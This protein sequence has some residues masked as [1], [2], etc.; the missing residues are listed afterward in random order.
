MLD[1]VSGEKMALRPTTDTRSYPVDRHWI[2]ELLIIGIEEHVVFNKSFERYELGDGGVNVH[3]TDGSTVTGR[4]VIG[5]DGAHSRVRRQFLPESRLLDLERTIIWGRTPL[6]PEF[7]KRFNRPDVLAEHFACMVDPNDNRH[8][9]FFAPLRWSGNGKLSRVSEKLK[10]QEDYM[11]LALNFE[12]PVGKLDTK[13]AREEHAR[14]IS[15]G[16]DADLCNLLTMM[17]ESSA[18]RVHSSRP[19]VEVW[20]TDDR[21]TLLGDAIHLMSPSGGSGGL[22]AIQDAAELTTVLSEFWVDGKWVDLKP[23]MARYEGNMRERAKKAIDVSF[24][25]GK[26]LWAG[27]DWNEYLEVENS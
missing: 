12:T 1:A 3:F 22:T 16:W 26:F 24:A 15:Q 27:K 19:D 25:G 9:L 21:V 23:G 7:E 18:I 8:S 6:T 2:R 20:E 5:A 13:E 4:M 11:F 10:D 17:D 14:K